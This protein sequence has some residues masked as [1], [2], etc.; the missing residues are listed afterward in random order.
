MNFLRRFAL[1]VCFALS[2]CAPIQLQLDAEDRKLLS[3]NPTIYVVTFMPA[4]FEVDTSANVALVAG[5]FGMAGAVVG[6]AVSVAAAGVAAETVRG[7][8]VYPDIQ[9]DPRMLLKSATYEDP[10]RQVRDDLVSTLRDELKTAK[11]VVIEHPLNDDRP[12]ILAERFHDG[13]VLGLKTE[14]WVLALVQLSSDYWIRYRASA[15]FYLPKE[16]RYLW[17]EVCG[18]MPK[19]STASLS[20]LAANSGLGLKRL[21]VDTGTRCAKQLARELI[22]PTSGSSRLGE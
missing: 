17:R 5:M 18:F 20:E 16:N 1:I 4:P 3:S 6:T 8:N 19:D 2:S 21:L 10:A 9:N 11:F 12:K 15:M 22:Q 14:E 13:V 7:A